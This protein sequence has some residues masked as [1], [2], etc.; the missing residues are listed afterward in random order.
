[1][2][3]GEVRELIV[4][5]E[6]L[7]GNPLGDPTR[8]A[9]PVYLPPEDCW[10]GGAREELP[11]VLV[12]AGYGGNGRNNLVGTPWDPSFT[13][14]YEALLAADAVA[15]CA[16]AFPDG[17]TRLG[18]SQYM[19]SSAIGRYQDHV[20]DELLPAVQRECGVGLRR[21][22]RGLMGKSSG[23][24]ASLNL[25]WARPEDFSGLACQSGDAY[26]ELGYKPDFPKL[27]T[28]LERLGGVEAFVAHFEAAQKKSTPLF[29]A[30]NA[31]CMAACYSPNEN[32]PLGIDLP[33]E[34]H[35]G[36][37]RQEV[38]ARWLQHDPVERAPAEGGKLRDYACVFVDCGTADEFHLQF[39]A[40]QLVA[41]LREAGVTVTHEE[42]DGGH[43]GISYRYDVSL[44]LLTRALAG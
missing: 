6:V 43:M 4:E 10:P 36:R 42:F 41:A 1:M 23:G 25:A 34:L 7:R 40:R 44:P 29:L 12:L 19:N 32:A 5:S 24:F 30:M 31:L 13:E 11:L 27:L 28:Q 37:L 35:T 39:G 2:L 22:R 3:R 21:E 15:P 20:L 16:F 17:F 9:L 18:G 38:W 14:R 8:R 26:F 33:V